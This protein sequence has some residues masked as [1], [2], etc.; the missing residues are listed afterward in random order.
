M[1]CFLT[2]CNII[3]NDIGLHSVISV[4]SRH[5]TPTACEVFCMYQLLPIWLSLNA[6]KYP[7]EIWK[8]PNLLLRHSVRVDQISWRPHDRTVRASWT[9]WPRPVIITATDPGRCLAARRNGGQSHR[10]FRGF[11]T[12]IVKKVIRLNIVCMRPNPWILFTS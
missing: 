9:P 5:S 2:L 3:Q 7:L 12:N 1:L 6:I 8:H 4:T 11:L 10:L